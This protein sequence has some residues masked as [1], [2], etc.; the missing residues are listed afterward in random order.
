M[1]GHDRRQD[2]ELGGEQPASAATR[3]V[4][5]GAGGVAR[6]TLQLIKD[7]AAAGARIVC[8][9]FL[10]DTGFYRP[11]SVANLRVLG[12]AD[13]LRIDEEVAVVIAVGS[14]AARRRIAERIQQ[15]FSDRVVTLIHP[16]ATIGDTVTIGT[17][18]IAYAGC[19][20]TADIS[21]GAYVQLHV[22]CTIGH[23]ATIGSF[24]TIA[25]GANI[26]GWAEIGEG[27]LVGSGAVVLP[28]RK[29]GH[30]SVIGA[31]SVVT[32]D[33]PE[34]TTVAGAPA[35][36]VAQRGPG[37]HLDSDHDLIEQVYTGGF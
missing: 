24:V 6:E 1:H 20:A 31:G 14:P 28:R 2:A 30:W 36:I 17:G 4:I 23:D 13:W 12:D 22:S 19:V 25:P 15:N 8:T 5:Y 3:I 35:R 21:T 32:T 37:W 18:A 29:I 16:R 34:N 11:E 9:G 26:G 10:V 7:L 27:T 33:V